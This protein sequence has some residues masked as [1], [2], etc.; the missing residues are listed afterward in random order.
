MHYSREVVR[1]FDRPLLN[2]VYHGLVISNLCHLLSALVLSRLAL[3]LAPSKSRKSLAFLTAALHVLSPAGIFL[4]APYSESTFAL[5]NFLGQYCYALSVLDRLRSGKSNSR[6]SIY[7]LCSG[8]CF[9]VATSVRSNGL[10]SGLV[11]A[12]DVIV[13]FCSVSSPRLPITHITSVVPALH[14]DMTFPTPP[15]IISTVAA[16]LLVAL[17]LIWPQYLAYKEFC[18]L[19]SSSDMPPWCTEFPPSI[20]T[21]VQSRYWYVL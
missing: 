19:Q 10:L 4:T 17:G 1:I 3:A 18:G 7:V 13:W 20:Y 2:V 21:S 12:Y 8:V 5:L 14:F 9:A 16:G 6:Q 11:F 15:P